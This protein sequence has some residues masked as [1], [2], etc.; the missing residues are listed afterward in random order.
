MIIINFNMSTALSEAIFI[1][2]SYRIY[3]KS[4]HKYAF[5]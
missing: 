2:R 1:Y 5:L 4:V 3:A